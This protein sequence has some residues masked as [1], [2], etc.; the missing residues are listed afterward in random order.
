[1]AAGRSRA[2]PGRGGPVDVLGVAG[3]LA[4]L[5]LVAAALAAWPTLR[6]AVGIG[7]F[8]P[9]FADLA[10]V[11][12][13]AACPAP[14]AG[15]IGSS[16]CDPYG[17]P[18]NYP[19]VWRAVLHP[20]GVGPAATPVLGAVLVAVALAALGAV[21]TRLPPRGRARWGVAAT[22]LS[23]PLW[24]LLVRGN[25][26]LLVL[27][28]VAVTVLLAEVDAAPAV[29]VAVAAVAKITGLGAVAG[30]LRD[31]RQLGLAAVGGVVAL[32]T[33]AAD[34]G[35]LRAATPSRVTSSFGAGV[36]PAALRSGVDA[37]VSAADQL[38]GVAVVLAGAGVLLA[39]APVRARLSS[40]A[41]ALDAHPTARAATGS[42]AGLLLV[43]FL[44]T[45]SYDYR[46]APLVLLV[47]GLGAVGDAPG[48]GG[49]RRW[50]LALT[51]ATCWASYPLRDV[52]P[53]G[54]VLAAVLAAGAA[55]LTA[56]LVRRALARPGRSRR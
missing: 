39:L 3:P 17:R 20:L 9:P 7:R 8:P 15:T 1:M 22:V 52:Q 53:V 42:G 49:A 25:T 30:R 48:A 16:A 28:L 2:A 33:V 23:P 50:L 13:T 44:A 29:L 38:L 6:G 14:D 35:A 54:D 47:A 46:L 36:L 51:V 12:A 40:L 27:A 55:A 10:Q 34:L 37:D 26:D 43:A 41:D 45:T 24:L 18:Y 32:A 21:L 56:V 11:T 4:L 31:R 5:V 19:A